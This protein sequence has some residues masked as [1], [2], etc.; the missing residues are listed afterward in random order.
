[1]KWRYVVLSVAFSAALG[2][3]GVYTARAA[4]EAGHEVYGVYLLVLLCAMVMLFAYDAGVRKELAQFV[5]KF[6]W[7][8]DWTTPLTYCAC[9]QLHIPDG[10]IDGTGWWNCWWRKKQ[11][12]K[13]QAVIYEGF[14]HE[15]V[16]PAPVVE[17]RPG[18]FL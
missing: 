10:G 8:I 17:P 14:T 9:G 6:R 13:I 4:R 11:A 7:S 15:R 16:L 3:I 2:G 5:T 18:D 1:M 12:D